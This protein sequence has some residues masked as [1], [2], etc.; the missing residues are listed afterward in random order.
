MRAEATWNKRTWSSAHAD[1]V[2]NVSFTAHPAAIEVSQVSA[3]RHY[4]A[5]DS[6]NRHDPVSGAVTR[7]L[8]VLA[9]DDA[10]LQSSARRLDRRSI[11]ASLDR[12]K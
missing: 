1:I 11:P 5:R 10:R 12:S 9:F 2:E 3:G 4:F 7:L 6:A 8:W